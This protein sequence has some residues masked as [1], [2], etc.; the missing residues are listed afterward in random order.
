MEDFDPSMFPHF[1]Y[2]LLETDGSGSDTTA[3]V[4][5]GFP[6]T[7]GLTPLPCRVRLGRTTQV[8]IGTGDGEVSTT[9][10]QVAFPGDP[11]VAKGAR[12][13]RTTDA[14]RLR[15]LDRARARGGDGVLFVVACDVID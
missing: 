11:G 5:E 14:L 10:A 6:A 1:V 12:P 8:P 15:A 13:Q 3:S 4:V 2:I 7:S 9:E